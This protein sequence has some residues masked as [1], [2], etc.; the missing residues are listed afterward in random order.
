MRNVVL[1][2]KFN[3][4]KQIAFV[5]HSSSHPAYTSHCV[6]KQHHF[7]MGMLLKIELHG[8]VVS[9][10][11]T[12]GLCKWCSDRDVQGS[13]TNMHRLRRYGLWADAS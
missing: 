13:L 11:G 7:T 3:I 9:I 12:R 1:E 4:N 2:K 6:Y 10:S 8:V 5:S